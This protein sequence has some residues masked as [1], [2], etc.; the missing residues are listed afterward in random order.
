MSLVWWARVNRMKLSCSDANDSALC[1]W[2]QWPGNKRPEVSR[3]VE[4]KM[5]CSMNSQKVSLWAGHYGR[6]HRTFFSVF[7]SSFFLWLFFLFPHWLLK[8]ILNMFIDFRDSK[9]SMWERNIYKL[10]PICSWTGIKPA[11][12]V[13]AL[14][15]NQTHN[16]LL[17]GSTLQPTE[18]YWPG[19]YWL[20]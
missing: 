3:G 11:T 6:I 1:R 16:L 20:S 15:G 18:P 4:G 7:F 8:I 17:Y 2:N 5:I 14:T 13:C 10:P 19:L 12:Q 9:T